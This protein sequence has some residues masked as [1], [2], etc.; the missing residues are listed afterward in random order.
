[1]AMCACM[2]SRFSR[3]WLFAA[4]RT[5]VRQASLSLG[6]SRHEYWSQL[7]PLPG[8]LPDPGIKLVYPLLLNCK[9][10]LLPRCHQ[11]SPMC[12]HILTSNIYCYSVMVLYVLIYNIA[13]VLVLILMRSSLLIFLFFMDCYFSGMFKKNFILLHFRFE[14][15]IYFD[16]IVV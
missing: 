15:V 12:G 8:D 6:F 13:T 14:N 1:M 11:G 7:C 9:Q 5:V 4:L 3:V 2:L 16:L 10:I